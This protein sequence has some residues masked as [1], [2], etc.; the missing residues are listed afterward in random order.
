MTA[1][2]NQA[3]GPSRAVESHSYR[4]SVQVPK[5]IGDGMTWRTLVVPTNLSAANDHALD[6]RAS[7]ISFGFD[8]AAVDEWFRTHVRCTE[9]KTAVTKERD[10]PLTF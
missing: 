6:L 4:V 5:V 7:L 1:S 2:E 3:D 10:L 8:S 9:Y